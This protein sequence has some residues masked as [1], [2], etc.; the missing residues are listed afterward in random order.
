[1]SYFL[2]IDM[3]TT[4]VAAGVAQDHRA[5]IIDLGNRTAT[6]PSVVYLR[7]DETVL[8]GEA[9]LR[10]AATDSSR[11]AR[12]FKRRFGDTTPILLGG[13][14]YSA[15]G[16]S[17]KLLR[18]VYDQVVEL[19][20]AEPERLTVC[21]PAN[22]GDFKLDLL[23]QTVRR[24]DLQAS[25]LSEPEAAAIFYA[26]QQRVEPGSV[27][28]VYDL[29]GGTFDAAVLRKTE[30]SFQ[31]L[32]EPEGIE[33]LGG[34]DFDEAVFHYVVDMVG[35]ALHELDP[36]EPGTVA[37][38]TRLRTDCVEAKEALSADT[39]AL[40]P[41]SF[42]GLHTEV[43]L[44]R[45]ELEG[46]IRPTLSDSLDAT[47]RAMRSASVDPDE[48]SAVVLVGGSSRIPLVGQ[49]VSAEF[50]RPVAVDTHPK[51]AIALGA[52]LHA[53]LEHGVVPVSDPVPTAPPPPLS[54]EAEAAAPS[55]PAV[56]PVVAAALPPVETDPP[57]PAPSF[58]PTPEELAPTQVVPVVAAASHPPVEPSSA[59]AAG[60]DDA[61]PRTGRSSKPVVV[62]VAIAAALVLLGGAAF[63]LSPDD[64]KPAGP[65]AST[66]LVAT[67]VP[68][69]SVP[70]ATT[71]VPQ[72]GT[73]TVPPTTIADPG[74]QTTID[75]IA[76]D[77]D[78]YDISWQANFTADV[79]AQH[80]HLFWDTVGV[81][82]AG[83]Q[84]SGPWEL[85]DV[86][87]YRSESVLRPSN[88]PAGAAAICITA[89]D[90]GHAVIDF[91]VLHCMPA[92]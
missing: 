69:T 48:V 84:G 15:D 20:G 85:T 29:G 35:P 23:D 64:N 24:A 67:T 53:E 30:Q 8:A 66:T 88:R 70:R 79:N 38:M 46:L 7:D 50:G 19:Q 52:A 25:K 78:A 81:E 42:P 55:G 54:R 27:V 31:I 92:P 72:V 63:A 77:G 80:V 56:V 45:S 51:H 4:Y 11:F 17:A 6:I 65:G 21:H 32:G 40:I 22:W 68:P 91:G 39:E 1:V 12:E 34:I 86:S 13:T 2:G 71:T 37:A 57:E 5:E 28:V 74:I 58:D 44:T 60:F 47:R 73:T 18:C 89:A 59:P 87:P 10:R 76:V 14:P 41:V 49:L 83:M 62:L 3:G 61:R 9:A 36:D 43:R 33:R 16:L 90:A 82:N 26:S 75:S